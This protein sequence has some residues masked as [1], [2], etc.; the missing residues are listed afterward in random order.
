MLFSSEGVIEGKVFPCAGYGVIRE[1]QV[2]CKKLDDH[3]LVRKKPCVSVFTVCGKSLFL[4]ITSRE[5]GFVLAFCEGLIDNE[6][7]PFE[8][9]VFPCPE[10]VIWE[11]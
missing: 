7:R 2:V 1:A 4:D 6:T 10:Y 9:D 11:A 5:E 3:F 8:R